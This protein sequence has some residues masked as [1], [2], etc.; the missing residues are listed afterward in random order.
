VTE[1]DPQRLAEEL[2]R[3]AEELA[4]RSQEL[5]GKVEQTRQELERKRA[6]GSVPGAPPAH[7]A[8][9][10]AGSPAPEAPAKSD[11]G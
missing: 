4:R 1:E 8:N 9:E 11:D 10:D 7:G 6:D 3:E 2:E 5:Q